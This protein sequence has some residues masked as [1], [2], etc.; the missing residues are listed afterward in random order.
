VKALD[1]ALGLAV[2]ILPAVSAHAADGTNNWPGL[3]DDAPCLT[4]Q[5]P[6]GRTLVWAKPGETGNALDS[7]NWTEY[8]LA[9]DYTAGKGGKPA[10][11]VSDANTDL[12]LPDAPDDRSYIVGYMVPARHRTG[13]EQSDCPTLACRHVTIGANA[14]LDG[15]MGVMRGKASYSDWSNDDRAV[16]ISGNVTVADGGYIY[17]H[18]HFV[19]D[20]HTQFSMGKSPEPLYRSLLVRKAQGASVTFVTRQFDVVDGV[21][22]ESGRLVLASTANLRINAGN[23]PRIDL[24]KLRHTYFGRIEPYIRVHEKAALEMLPGSRIGRVNPPDDI[25]ADMRIEGLLQ[26]GRPGDTNVAPA[27]IELTMAEGDGKFLNQP[28]GLYIQPTA[29]VRNF[30]TL[31][32]T[33]KDPNTATTGK[34]VSIFLEKEVDLGKVRIDGLCAGGI[35][36]TD[37][38]AAKKALASAMFGEHCAAADD[39]IYSKIEFIDFA[40]GMGTV[41]FVDGLTTE[42]EILPAE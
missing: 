39:A 16:A 41:E 18:L 28:G 4:E 21:T 14:A 36:A 7:A 33:A 42:C 27:V 8:A 13:S 35:A 9:A 23:Q 24:K 29:E 37:L 20:K 11:T 30:G 19:G 32:I 40:G 10:T 17:G 6:A 5:W 34:G 1:F 3:A 26:I 38:T 12:I 2:L 22:V 25:T 31:S 15:G